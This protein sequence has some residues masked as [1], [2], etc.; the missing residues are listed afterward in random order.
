MAKRV[1]VDGRRARLGV[2]V[3]LAGLALLV[4]TQ[5]L[6]VDSADS[7][8]ASLNSPE[9]AR[10]CVAESAQA[11]DRDRLVFMIAIAASLTI[12]AVGGALVFG[13]RRRVF[14]IAG[15]AE[16]LETDAEGL[17][18]LLENGDLASVTFDGRTHVDAMEVER[19][20]RTPDESEEMAPGRA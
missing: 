14:D 17:R 16:L 4:S 8:C 1:W 11:L 10:E 15:A 9:R 12:V 2:L 19:L 6:R 5:A 18:S 7:T 3:V 20:T 13:A